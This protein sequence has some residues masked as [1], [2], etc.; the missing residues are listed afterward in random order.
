MCMFNRIWECIKQH[1]LKAFWIIVIILPI[2]LYYFKFHAFEWSNK[3]EDWGVFGDYIGGVYSVII[4]VLVVYLAR[5]L[6]RKDE[7][8]RLRRE[9]L[10]EVYY[11]IV[12]IQQNQQPNQNKVTKLYR[13]IEQCKLF[14]DDD[15]YDRLKALA[16]VFGEYKRDR[17]MEKDL[18]DEVKSE[19]GR[20]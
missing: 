11:Q 4:A 10:R 1:W 14:I 16:N 15:F 3:P 18:L 17:E 7:E 5:N 20:K 12:S 19:Y 13:L 9:S 6:N 2:G 8:Q